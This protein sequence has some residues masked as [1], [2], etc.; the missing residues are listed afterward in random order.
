[1]VMHARSNVIAGAVVTSATPT[2][3]RGP[4]RVAHVINNLEVGGAEVMLLRLVT[5]ASKERF[6]YSVISLIGDGPIGERLRSAG[7]PTHVIGMNA[8]RPSVPGFLRLARTLR[9][10]DPEVVQT[11]M[12]HSDLLGGMAARMATRAPVVWGIHHTTFDGATK[13]TTRLTRFACAKL[14]SRIP[15]GIVSCSARAL[16]VHEDAGYDTRRAVVIPN[17][18]DTGAFAPDGE[19]RARAR[20]GLGIPDG[21]FVVGMAARYD[22]QKDFPTF[23]RMAADVVRRHP[24]TV[25]LLAGSRVD[26]GNAAL[27]EMLAREGPASAVRLLGRVDDMPGFYNALDVCVLSSSYGE[28]FPLAIGEAMASGVPC[29]ATDVG[30]CSWMI[31]DAGAVVPPSNPLAL[32]D[33]V[34][35]ILELSGPERGSRARMAREHVVAAF[36]LAGVARRYEALYEGV[37]GAASSDPA[38]QYP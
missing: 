36:S 25:F 30:E 24:N 6:D 21:S 29:V 33:A 13:L 17:G 2:A 18:I 38:P 35:R 7:I 14:S 32:A 1:M 31:G 5:S 10:L 3:L 20:A 37:S 23:A 15:S 4:I 27:V 19:L 16:S 11:W 9:R 28:A 12:Y 26:P 22:P 34:C 8:G